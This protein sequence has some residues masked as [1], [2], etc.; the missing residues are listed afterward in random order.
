MGPL[1]EMGL[2]D[3]V[4]YTSVLA[5]HWSPSDS[6]DLTLPDQLM[7]VVD[8]IQLTYGRNCKIVDC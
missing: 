7:G 3:E 4:V 5:L 1:D 6:T 8:I 2:M